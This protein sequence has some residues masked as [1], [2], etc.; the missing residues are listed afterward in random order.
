MATRTP[1]FIVTLQILLDENPTYTAWADDGTCFTITDP[2][3]FAR[4]VLGKYFNHSRLE[5]FIRQLYAYGFKRVRKVYTSNDLSF[6]HP[7]FQRGNDKLIENI[8]R[9]AS[10]NEKIK[11]SLFFFQFS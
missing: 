9:N 2:T 10:T 11:T 5:S 3:E 4:N 8:T 1:S 7:Y 6:S